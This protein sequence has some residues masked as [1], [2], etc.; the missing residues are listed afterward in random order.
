MYDKP[1]FLR[2]YSLL[3]LTVWCT[4]LAWESAHGIPFTS[5]KLM[6]YSKSKGGPTQLYELPES[7]NYNAC[8]MI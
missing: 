3:R 6:T 4:S 7:R 5:N 2:Q 8:T 1:Q